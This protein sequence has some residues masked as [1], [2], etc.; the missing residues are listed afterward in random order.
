MNITERQNCAQITPQTLS[1][2]FIPLC[3]SYPIQ[4][5]WSR[6]WNNVIFSGLIAVSVKYEIEY[7]IGYIIKWLV[8]ILSIF[9][10]GQHLKSSNKTL[11]WNI[12]EIL[13]QPSGF[14][15][16][17]VRNL[18]VHLADSQFLDKCH[19]CWLPTTFIMLI[20]YEFFIICIQLKWI[21]A[22]CH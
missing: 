19:G 12:M 11:K 20:D 16:L 22:F 4:P 2:L 7:T 8:Y 1:F 15:R 10:H 18:A 13:I 21:V 14:I 6:Q 3:M 17:N 9:N 5:R